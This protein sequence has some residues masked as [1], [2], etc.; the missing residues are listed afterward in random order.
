MNYIHYIHYFYSFCFLF[1]YQHVYCLY[2]NDHTPY[3]Y[4]TLTIICYHS[5]GKL[6]IS[7]LLVWYFIITKIAEG[8]K[9]VTNYTQIHHRSLSQFGASTSVKSLMA[10]LALWTKTSTLNEVMRSCKW[11]PHVSKMSTLTYNWVNSVVMESAIIL[12]ILNII[13]EP[14]IH[15]FCWITCTNPRKCASCIYVWGGSILFLFIWFFYWNYI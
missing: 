14:S 9:I 15:C 2:I 4:P 11:F 7:P 3:L 13:K 1:Y 5:R 6:W 8:G 10:K 12:N